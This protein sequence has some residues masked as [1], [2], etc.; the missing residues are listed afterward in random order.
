MR[1]GRTP[2]TCESG[3]RKRRGGDVWGGGFPVPTGGGV[4]GG[5]SAPS[6]ENFSISDLKMVS[7]D[8]FCVVFTV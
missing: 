5:G 7:F 6:P 8:A 2:K 3:R 1:R 4:W